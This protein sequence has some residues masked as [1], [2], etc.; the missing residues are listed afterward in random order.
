MH[1]WH[2][3]YRLVHKLMPVTSELRTQTNKLLKAPV[4]VNRMKSFVDP[5]DRRVGEPELPPDNQDVPVFLD[6]QEHEIP[7]DSFETPKLS[8]PPP[9]SSPPNQAPDSSSSVTTPPSSNNDDPI[10]DIEHILKYRTCKE[11]NQ[12]LVKWKGFTSKHNSW[13]PVDSLIRKPD[14]KTPPSSPPSSPSPG[15]SHQ[16][17]AISFVCPPRLFSSFVLNPLPYFLLMISLFTISHAFFPTPQFGPL[18]DCSHIKHNAIFHL[19]QTPNNC[20]HSMYDRNHS[21]QYFYADVQQPITQ[22]TLI[23][24]FHCIADI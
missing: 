5:T 14:S 21:V 16:T 23:T 15:P 12:C 19:P 10:Y 1:S 22:R 2:G 6:L 4:H 7:D 3:P 11:E 17:N 13:I 8:A 24:L 9:C 18:Y 20:S